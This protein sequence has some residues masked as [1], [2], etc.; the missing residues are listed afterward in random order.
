M[1]AVRSATLAKN[2]SSATCDHSIRFG[3]S[4]MLYAPPTP[5]AHVDLE[6]PDH[7]AR[8]TTL[9]RR[10]IHGAASES[11]RITHQHR[12]HRQL[13]YPASLIRVEIQDL[14]SLVALIVLGTR[15]R[16]VLG[17]AGELE[18]GRVATRQLNHANAN[19]PAWWP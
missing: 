9:R 5:T 4:L 17:S 13:N 15:W 3:D 18:E 7:S 8:S 11:I 2:E 14:P 10:A 6:I 1:S 19:N 12:I 16:I